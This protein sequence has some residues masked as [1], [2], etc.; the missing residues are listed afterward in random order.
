MENL[1]VSSS[2]HLTGNA[3]TRR[4]MLDVII[5][6][7]PACVASVILFGPIC[8]GIISLSIIGAV[9]AEYICRKIMKRDCT[10]GDLSAVVTGILLALNL[11]AIPDSLWMAPLGSAIAIT[12]VKQFFGGLGHNF[13]NPA[14]VGRIVLMMSFAGSMARSKWPDPLAWME[15]SDAIAHATVLAGGD[16]PDITDLLLGIRGGCLGETCAIALVIGFI[17]MC[18]RRVI[19]PLIPLTFCGTTVLCCW[20]FDGF[21]ANPAVILL[22]GGLLLGSIF[23]ATDYVTT[24]STNGGKVVFAVG[25]GLITALIRSFGSLPEGVSFAILIMNILTPHIDNLFKTKPFGARKGA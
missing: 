20:A 17:Y 1:I 13:A 7:L 11:P 25:C 3:T 12:V 8:L 4:I 5:A 16:T 15:G 10:T 22:S 2:P 18:L 14:I 24:P 6:L 21:S 19:T 23:M 9:A